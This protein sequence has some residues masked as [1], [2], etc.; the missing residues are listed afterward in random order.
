P[1]GPV[2]SSRFRSQ[3]FTAK[4]QIAPPSGTSGYSPGYSAFN[5]ALT[6]R[7]STPQPDCTATYCVPPTA[8]VVGVPRT[9]ELVGNSHSTFP[10]FA[11]YA[12]NNRSLVPP[13]NTSPPLV[14]SIGPQLIDFGNVCV[15]TRRPVSTFQACTSPKWSAP[16][17]N[18]KLSEAPV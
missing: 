15:Q 13:L 10:F 2:N 7:A 18:S 1:A 5:R 17:A 14:A 6:P 9:P 16:G 8:N 3:F 12:R 4:T 11:S